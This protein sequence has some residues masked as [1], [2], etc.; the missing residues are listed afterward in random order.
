MT[1]QKKQFTVLDKCKTIKGTR[2]FTDC[3]V[4]SVVLVWELALAQAGIFVTLPKDHPF[5]TTKE[6]ENERLIHIN[7][8]FVRESIPA[9]QLAKFDELVAAA[10]DKANLGD[11]D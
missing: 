4:P 3:F 9:S 10:N 7:S 6:K 8:E 11:P 2:I 1:K 5:L